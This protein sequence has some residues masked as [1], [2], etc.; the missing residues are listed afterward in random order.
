[1]RSERPEELAC[2][3]IGCAGLLCFS[4]DQPFVAPH[5]LPVAPPEQ[6]EGP[7]RQR[8]TG[9]PLALSVVDEATRGELLP[10]PSDQRIGLVPLGRADRIRIPFV[11]LEIID[12]HESR[13]AAHGQAYVVLL[14]HRIDLVTQIVEPCP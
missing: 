10:E 2:A 9:I 6:R 12:G 1:S 7:A 5:G 8:L 11:T 4:C 14:Q 3:V 13:L